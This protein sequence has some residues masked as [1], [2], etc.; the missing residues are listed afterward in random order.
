MAT[1]DTRSPSAGASTDVAPAS[2]DQ[3]PGPTTVRRGL[4]LHLVL[5]AV[6]LA[7]VALFGNLASSWTSDDGVYAVQAKL[8]RDEGR[9]D[10]PQRHPTADP[11]RRHNPLAHT[12]VTDAGRAYPYIQQPAWIVAMAST[13]SL[14]GRVVGLHLPAYLGAIG[15]A[16]IGWVLAR[17]LSP[18]L[19]LP[20]FWAVGLGAVL[21]EATALWA[22]S[23]AAALGGCLAV[24]IVRATDRKLGWTHLVGL[25]AVC[26]SAVMLRREGLLAVAAVSL[27]LGAVG[28]QR[29]RAGRG[30]W[31]HAAL[32]AVLAAGSGLVAH[33]FNRAWLGTIV[34]G[35]PIEVRVDAPPARGLIEGRVTG[36]L[37]TVLDGRGAVPL[38]TVLAL[39]AVG[40]AVA[41]GLEWRERRGL[42]RGIV[43]SSAAVA[44]VVLRSVVAE[45]DGAGLLVA[46][47]LLAAGLGAWRWSAAD[48]AERSLAGFVV[49]YAS[50]V[51]A[52]QYPEGGGAE[53]GGR[54]LFFALV[55]A[56]CLTLSALRRGAF[57]DLGRPIPV[58]RPSTNP[59]TGH[60]RSRLVAGALALLVLVPTAT[61]LVVTTRAA[62]VNDAL[63]RRTASIQG[64][65]VILLDRFVGRWG[66]RD[67][68]EDD[69]LFAEPADAGDLLERLLPTATGPIT[70]LGSDAEAVRAE[71]Y[72]REQ[73]APSEVVF[74]PLTVDG[75]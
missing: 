59:G 71:G 30:R 3:R 50:F 53:W 4:A 20:A 56:T 8:V 33:L 61:G 7:V 74:H 41:A 24:V 5:F 47:P 69:R 64:D 29:L 37:R 36:T 67:L 21:I 12:T 57:V 28:W 34:Q 26:A 66:W 31:H 9:W 32:P 2:G 63:A 65:T 25:A 51:L 54:Y 14:A 75:G 62:D 22:H 38:A 44:L 72:R 68:P 40:L 23:A 55:P 73:V 49:V 6:V 19:E 17:R 45:G 27:V 13:S 15:A 10:L 39:L 42:V 11:D 58:P 46:M 1:T 48:L 43:L 60:H 16:A 35:A 52:T 18:G 70:V